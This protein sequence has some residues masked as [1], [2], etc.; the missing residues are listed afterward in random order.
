MESRSPILRIG[1]C[2]PASFPPYVLTVKSFAAVLQATTALLPM[3]KQLDELALR[4]AWAA[5]PEQ[6]KRELSDRD[7]AWAASQYL[8]DTQRSQ[9]DPIAIALLRY[10]YRQ[11]DGRPRLEWGL[12]YPEGTPSIGDGFADLGIRPEGLP[13]AMAVTSSLEVR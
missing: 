2:R 7:L 8:Q 12:R 9:G 5:F 11:G 10:L 3:G 6:A 1:C 4:L 13:A